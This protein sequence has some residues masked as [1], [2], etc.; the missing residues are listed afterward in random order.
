M[1]ILND[2]AKFYKKH[3][4][5]INI[6]GLVI[7]GCFLIYGIIGFF[8]D[9]TT[10]P[11]YGN[12]LD[13]IKKVEIKKDKLKELS[14]ALTKEEKISEANVYI[15]GKI[16]MVNVVV[17]DDTS[18]D[19]AQKEGTSIVNNLK[20]KELKFYDIELFISKKDEK[21]NNFPIIGHKKAG[22]DNFSWTKNREVTE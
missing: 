3:S 21:Q 22:K 9:N 14:E 13:G 19:E 20:K 5:I 11:I 7:I 16:I 15:E 12:R 1:K 17:D 10:A 6:G 2:L 18:V 4:N 8:G